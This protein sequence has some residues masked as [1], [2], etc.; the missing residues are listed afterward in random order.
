MKK[1]MNKEK[2]ML[3]M[4]RPKKFHVKAARWQDSMSC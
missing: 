4:L 2:L 1:K 3:K